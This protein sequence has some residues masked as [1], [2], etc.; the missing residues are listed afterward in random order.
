MQIFNDQTHY[1]GQTHA[2]LT[3]AGTKPDDTD[4]PFIPGEFLA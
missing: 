1:R 3:A 2:M 4:L